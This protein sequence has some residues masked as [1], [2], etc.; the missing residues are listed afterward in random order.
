MNLYAQDGGVGSDLR[1]SRIDVHRVWLDVA[2]V[3]A[4]PNRV[5]DVFGRIWRSVAPGCRCTILEF[6][7]EFL[8]IW[9]DWIVEFRGL[10]GTRCLLRGVRG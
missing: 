1:F 9:V 6:R 2:V 3:R 4:T 5:D 7:V 8:G 10:L